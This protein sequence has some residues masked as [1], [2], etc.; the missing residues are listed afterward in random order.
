MVGIL[1][2]HVLLHNVFMVGLSEF[3][4]SQL[5]F[6]VFSSNV[7]LHNHF[8]W[9]QVS[10]TSTTLSRTFGGFTHQGRDTEIA[11]KIWKIFQTSKRDHWKALEEQFLMVP[12]VL[13]LSEPI[14][15][16]SFG[17]GGL[18]FSKVFSNQSYQRYLR[19][20][21]KVI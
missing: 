20:F 6:I 1:Y 12:L 7:H 10:L 5:Y 17:E 13:K 11:P 19:K 8:F 21:Q 4:V 3:M 9:L 15:I 2:R 16:P 14:D 18:K